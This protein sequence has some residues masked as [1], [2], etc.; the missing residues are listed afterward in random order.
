MA[1]SVRNLRIAEAL[2][3][4]LC[5]EL[6]SPVGAIANG[7]EILAEDAGFAADAATLIGQ[8]A[9]QASRR[10]QFYRLAYGALAEVGADA[11]RQ[12]TLELFAEGRCRCEWLP[13]SPVPDPLAKVMMNLLLLAAA[14]L[15]RGG[16]VMPIARDGSLA[17]TAEGAG[18]RLDDDLP[19]LL[20]QTAPPE[21]I[22]PKTVQ[23]AFTAALAEAAG[24]T[25]RTAVD[26]VDRV[27]FGLV[28]SLPRKTL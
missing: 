6:V 20:A 16:V 10:L 27:R 2:A 28:A 1:A 25:I 11:A 13:A 5:H 15:P 17:V 26:G 12:A 3:A 4:R 22:G 7:V 19:E 21:V 8:S 9:A 24:F 23:A 18:A 14:T